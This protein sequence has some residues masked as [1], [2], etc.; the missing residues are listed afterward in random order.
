M[1]E[2]V[3]PTRSGTEQREQ[4]MATTEQ[5]DHSKDSSSSTALVRDAFSTLREL[6]SKEFQLARAEAREGLEA[7]KQAAVCVLI[8]AVPAVVSL[9]LLALALTYALD[10]FLPQWAAAL[11]PALVLASVSAGLLFFG[12]KRLKSPDATPDQTIQNLK[13]DQQWLKQELSGQ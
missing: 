10:D 1:R 12:I 3:K 11:V 2:G 9:V 5:V 13:E 8:A 7:L 6:W 4:R